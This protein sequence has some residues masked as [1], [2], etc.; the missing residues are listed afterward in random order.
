M[1]PYEDLE[2]DV[3]EMTVIWKKKIRIVL[4]DA[5]GIIFMHMLKSGGW[6]KPDN[7]MISFE[8]QVIHHNAPE[9]LLKQYIKQINDRF[10]DADIPVR[11]ERQRNTVWID[12]AWRLTY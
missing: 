3:S 2:F 1:S 7:L 12:G 8:G 6:V 9:N 10:R 11:I 4:T 5:Q